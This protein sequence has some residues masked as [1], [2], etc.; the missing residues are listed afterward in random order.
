MAL[1][2]LDEVACIKVEA[3]DEDRRC[4]GRTT[5]AVWKSKL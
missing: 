3:R 1:A 5:D 4:A 2:G